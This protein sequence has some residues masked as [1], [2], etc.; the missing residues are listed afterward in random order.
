[1]DYKVHVIS[2]DI[3]VEYQYILL[4]VS[5]TIQLL[6]MGFFAFHCYYTGILLLERIVGTDIYCV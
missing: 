3:I 4:C 2:C 5:I 1:M 6:E